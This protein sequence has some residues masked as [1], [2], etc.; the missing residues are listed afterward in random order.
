MIIRPAH[1]GDAARIVDFWNPLILE[2]TVTFSDI[3]M[4]TVSVS[5][6]IESRRAAGHEFF[7][8]EIDGR[9]MGFATYVQFRTNNGYRRTVEH[10]IILPPDAHGLGIGRALMTAVEQ[11][12]AEAG[13][14]SIFAGVSAENEAG[15]AFHAAVGY[16]EVARLAEVGW[17]FNRWLDLVL[18]QKML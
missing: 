10:T 2:T 15:I 18:M 14:H 17:K 13:H 8:A 1:A 6:L 5:E 7:V 9:V 4:T 16:R 3:L 12:A 11:H